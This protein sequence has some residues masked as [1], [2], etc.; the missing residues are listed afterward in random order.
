MSD[1]ER[2]ILR[3]DTSVSRIAPHHT[4]SWD[5]TGRFELPVEDNS[6]VT[7]VF[8]LRPHLQRDVL[9]GPPKRERSALEQRLRISTA[10][11]LLLSC[12]VFFGPAIGSTVRA[13]F[14]G[15]PANAWREIPLAVS[16]APA[17]AAVFV[18]DELRGKTPLKHLE[19]CAGRLIRVRVQLKDHSIWQWSGFCPRHQALELTAQLQPA[20]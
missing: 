10:T 15:P 8:D 16:S 19:R 5:Q 18:D 4:P 13:W 17:G 2:D 9:H 3:V 7:G 6:V 20:P 11:L 1:D 14:G 12:V